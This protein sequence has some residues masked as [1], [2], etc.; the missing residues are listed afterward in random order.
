[1][2]GRLR[3]SGQVGEVEGCWVALGSAGRGLDDNA[4]PLGPVQSCPSK[5]SIERE[6][7]GITNAVQ[8]VGGQMP[9]SGGERGETR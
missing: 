2:L 8:T 3:T 6:G 4:A 1:M 9:G 5:K 7:G